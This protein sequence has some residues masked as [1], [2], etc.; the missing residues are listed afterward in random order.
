MAHFFFRYFV[1]TNNCF[2]AQIQLLFWAFSFDFRTSLFTF[3]VFLY[4]CLLW[5][6]IHPT[7]SHLDFISER[8]LALFHEKNLHAVPCN[9]TGEY[10]EI[11]TAAH[12]HFFQLW[13]LK[14]IVFFICCDNL[15]LHDFKMSFHEFKCIGFLIFLVKD[16]RIES[17]MVK[18]KQGRSKWSKDGQNEA[19]TVEIQNFNSRWSKWCS[20]FFNWLM[21]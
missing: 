11:K 20:H 14:F 6:W 18:M 5:S 3:L 2:E 19:K 16:G 9:Q 13:S 1:P 10:N 17:K 4:A 15:C 12:F 8:K 21:R 7:H